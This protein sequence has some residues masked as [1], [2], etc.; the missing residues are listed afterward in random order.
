M[1]L[2][3]VHA[4]ADVA[5]VAAARPARR[6]RRRLGTRAAWGA[7]EPGTQITA[8][9][10]SFRASNW[11][12]ARTI[13][14]T[15]RRATAPSRAITI[16][17][18]IVAVAGLAVALTLYAPRLR[19]SIGSSPACAALAIASSRPMRC[20]C[21][22]CACVAP[23]SRRSDLSRSADRRLALFARRCGRHNRMRACICPRLWR[24]IDHARLRKPGR[25]AASRCAARARFAVLFAV[26]KLR[27]ALRAIPIA[28]STPTLAAIVFA[29]V[30]VSSCL[31]SRPRSRRTLFTFRSRAFGGGSR[32][33]REPGGS[34]SGA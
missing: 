27:R 18:G 29:A 3:P 25:P 14:M 8:A 17:G 13:G 1:L 20:R 5:D 6:H 32:A 16:G 23:A 30:I 24:R 22:A 31:R 2:A 10:C 15:E 33:I 21:A 4:R 7:L 12:K 26:R 28:Q 19:K 9:T 34:R 11:R